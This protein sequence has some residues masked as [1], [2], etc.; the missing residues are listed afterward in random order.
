MEFLTSDY[1]L[2]IFVM[3]VIG[4]GLGIALG[5]IT[6]KVSEILVYV[7]ILIFPFV[8]FLIYMDF[9]PDILLLQT[10]AAEL[11]F[12]GDINIAEITEDAFV[13]LNVPYSFVLLAGFSSAVECKRKV[14]E[15]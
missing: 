1:F 15:A 10:I 7:F 12:P 2:V 8:Q 5:K 14:I 11:Y 6:N 4:F 9:I 13:L 3:C